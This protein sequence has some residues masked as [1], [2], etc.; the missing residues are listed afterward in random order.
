MLLAIQLLLLSISIE[1]TAFGDKE[2]SKRLLMSSESSQNS[3]RAGKHS[4]LQLRGVQFPSRNL[5]SSLDYLDKYCEGSLCCDNAWTQKYIDL[6]S[7]ILALPVGHKDRQF[8][9]YRCHGKGKCHG[10][11]DRLQGVYIYFSLA[12]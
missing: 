2:G 5:A 12:P 10:V 9:V 8:L 6:H 1:G 4:P 3:L 11:G 7:K